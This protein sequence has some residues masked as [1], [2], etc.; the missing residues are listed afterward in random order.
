MKA[1]IEIAEARQAA[2][3]L[4]ARYDAEAKKSQKEAHF[5]R[6][7][8]DSAAELAVKKA[9]RDAEVLLKRGESARLKAEDDAEKVC[10]LS[11]YR[12]YLVHSIFSEYIL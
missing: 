7:R 5:A 4:Q 10:Q 11:F 2:M 8:S 12:F 9:E 6:R 1:E 3:D